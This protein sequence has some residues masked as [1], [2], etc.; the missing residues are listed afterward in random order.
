[1]GTNP[2][3]VALTISTGIYWNVKK[4][5]NETNASTVPAIFYKK[6]IYLCL[7]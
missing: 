1:M 7:R 4:V 2:W 3:P 6:K 5:A